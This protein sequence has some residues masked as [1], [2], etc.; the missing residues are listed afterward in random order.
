MPF[1]PEEL[2]TTETD[3]SITLQEL[4]ERR[5]GG[6]NI[7]TNA[8]HVDEECFEPHIP[9]SLERSKEVILQDLARQRKVISYDK[10][11]DIDAVITG[12][13][14]ATMTQVIMANFKLLST[15]RLVRQ[16]TRNKLRSL[17]ILGRHRLVGF[18]I[19]DFAWAPG[20]GPTAWFIFL[21]D[22]EV[23]AAVH[24]QSGVSSISL[25]FRCI[26]KAM[27]L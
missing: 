19:G 15:I 14:L 7:E 12:C 3:N 1:R 24:Q 17:P 18:E 11:D 5:L 23:Q 26:Q 20:V 9:L 10:T 21:D 4:M 16:K 6:W 25:V 2:M 13:P 8:P 22:A 27:Q